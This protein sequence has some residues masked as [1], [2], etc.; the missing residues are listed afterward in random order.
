MDSQ[1]TYDN[2]QRLFAA[3]TKENPNMP[4]PR[5]LGLAETQQMAQERSR[6]IFTDRDALLAILDRYEDTLRKR[7]GKKAG[8]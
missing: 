4:M 7:W 2:P 1:S 3:M 6:A 8:E 5:F